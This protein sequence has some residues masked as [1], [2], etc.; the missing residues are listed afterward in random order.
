MLRQWRWLDRPEFYLIVRQIVIAVGQTAL[1]ALASEMSK[2]VHDV[3]RPVLPSMLV[4]IQ[5]QVAH[6]TRM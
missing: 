4:A 6:L 5:K 1:C 2:Y 3:D